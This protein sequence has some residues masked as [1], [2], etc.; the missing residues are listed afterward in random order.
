MAKA[1]MA[2]THQQYMSLCAEAKE[3]HDYWREWNPKLYEEAA[4]DGSLY[5]LV[6]TKGQQM[7]DE[8]DEL[9]FQQKLPLNQAREI[10]WAEIYRGYQT[11][12]PEQTDPVMDFLEQYRKNAMT[13][14]EEE[15]DAWMESYE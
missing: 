8:M 4:K 15:L 1:K 2:L 11:P 13:M 3:L 12:E 10:V 14:T 9:I 6:A 5:N 7:Q